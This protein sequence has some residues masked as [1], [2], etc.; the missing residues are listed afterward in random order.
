M[1]AYI[2]R[3]ILLIIPTLFGIML[4]IS[5]GLL[6]SVGAFAVPL[7][8][9][10]LDATF[11]QDHTPTTSAVSIVATRRNSDILYTVNR[12]CRFRSAKL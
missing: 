8:P 2:L 11:A 1:L 5:H 3:R 10:S 9:L 7:F 12:G 4:V 6:L